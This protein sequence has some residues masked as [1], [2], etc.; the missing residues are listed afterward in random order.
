MNIKNIYEAIKKYA[1]VITN[2][3]EELS[4]AE[5]CDFGLEYGFCFN[6]KNIYDNVYWCVNKKTAKITVFSPYQNPKKFAKRKQIDL[7][8]VKINADC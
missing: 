3:K 1:E 8:E 7:S 5:A 6:V 2:S 4:I